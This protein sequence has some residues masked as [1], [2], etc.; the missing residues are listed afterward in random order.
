MNEE[1]ENWLVEAVERLW[2]AGIVVVVSAGNY[3]PEQ[4][5]IAIPGNSRK[6]ITVGAYAKTARGQECSGRGP[7]K[8]CVQAG[9]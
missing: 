6:V 5:T 8:A 3:G 9:S 1:K 4:G 7:T 2:D